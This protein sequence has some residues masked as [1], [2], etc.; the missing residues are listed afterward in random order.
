MSEPTIRGKVVITGGTSGI[1][2]IAA[3]RRC[4]LREVGPDTAHRAI[5][6]IFRWSPGLGKRE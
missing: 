5:T 6:L 4:W 1:G 3:A 2:R